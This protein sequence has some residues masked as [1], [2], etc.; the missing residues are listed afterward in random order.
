MPQAASNTESILDEIIHGQEQRTQSPC[1]V[2]S[3]LEQL[4]DQAGSLQSA[5]DTASVTGVAIADV[6]RRRG[7]KVS[8]HTVQRH[9]R[10]A[11][12]CVTDSGT[13]G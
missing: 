11:C 10:G 3:I 9:R 12:S 7:F 1:T 13:R 2:R 4:E 8:S 6:L 5:L